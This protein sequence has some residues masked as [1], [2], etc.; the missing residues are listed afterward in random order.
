MKKVVLFDRL[1]VL[2]DA[3]VVED[4]LAEG[5][6]RV[7]L[8]A[9]PAGILLEL[10][11]GLV[12]PGDAAEDVAEAGDRLL[13]PAC[14]VALRQD[15]EHRARRAHRLG[16]LEADAGVVQDLVG[17]GRVGIVVEDL[18]VALAALDVL[19]GRPVLVDGLALAL[20][21][22]GLEPVPQLGL[23][24][25][26]LLHA[27]QDVDPLEHLAVLLGPVEGVEQQ[28]DRVLGGL[29]GGVVLDDVL[30]HRQGLVELVVAPEDLGLEELHHHQFLALILDEVDV[31]VE[32]GDHLLLALGDVLRGRDLGG[33]AAHLLGRTILG[34]RST[35]RAFFQ[36]STA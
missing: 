19:A 30:E 1:V 21:L 4:R 32:R 3:L 14:P 7:L 5:V 13:G 17:V 6:E 27:Q 23:G 15:V 29:V 12:V 18:Q 34:P 22:E 10:L 25:Q 8:A 9:E 2:T 20:P 36:P 16:V 28:V 26:L 11:G 35:S 24:G 33:G 31:D